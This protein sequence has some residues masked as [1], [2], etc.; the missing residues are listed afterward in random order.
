MIKYFLIFSIFLFFPNCGII[1]SGSWDDDEKNW[2][3]VFN[4]NTPKDIKIIHSYYSC[5]PYFILY[6]GSYI[7][8]IK[9]SDNYLKELINDP[10]LR[11]SDI[12]DNVNL[13]ARF[14]SVNREWFPK[15]ELSHYDVWIAKEGNSNYMVYIDKHS[16]L[17]FISDTM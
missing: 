17:I 3:R 12:T 7:F 6:E 13:L 2:N 4:E 8:Q 14:G 15:K 5:G 9:A 1:K 10:F 11:K 16:N